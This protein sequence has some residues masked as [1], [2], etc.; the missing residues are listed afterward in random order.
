MLTLPERDRFVV[1]CFMAVFPAIKLATE[2]FLADT[3]FVMRFLKR[4]SKLL[5][6]QRY[7]IYTNQSDYACDDEK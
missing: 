3:S 5:C 7:R 1:A 6:L 4:D 2:K